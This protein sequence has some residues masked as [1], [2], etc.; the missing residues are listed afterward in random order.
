MMMHSAQTKNTTKQAIA[1]EAKLVIKIKK[2][3]ILDSRSIFICCET[4]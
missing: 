2:C 3:T 1:V 4:K